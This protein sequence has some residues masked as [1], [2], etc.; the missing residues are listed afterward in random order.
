MLSIQMLKLSSIDVSGTDIW[1]E[2]TT[3]E[4]SSTPS[5]TVRL[6][7]L[8]VTRERCRI[9]FYHESVQTYDPFGLT[10]ETEA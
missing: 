8:A 9:S 5:Y 6:V 7:C 3:A 10:L 4:F 1:I 2:R